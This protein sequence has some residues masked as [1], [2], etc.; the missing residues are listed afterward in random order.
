M[1]MSVLGD[2]ET[3]DKMIADY[4]VKTPPQ[5]VTDT[6]DLSSAIRE[7]E[8]A[9]PGWWWSVCVCSL[10]RDSSC[11]PDMAGPDAHLLTREEFDHGFHCDDDGGTLASSLREVMRQALAAKAV[12]MGRSSMA[13]QA[14]YN[15]QAEGSIPSAPTMSREITPAQQDALGLKPWRLSDETVREI[16]R[17]EATIRR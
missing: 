13:E 10:T 7:F 11:G 3:L 1:R 15:R 5:P 14:A 2:A 4:R 8:A 12:L 6:D 16:E 17:I 9:L